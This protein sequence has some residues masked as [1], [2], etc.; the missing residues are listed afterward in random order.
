MIPLTLISFGGWAIVA[1]RNKSLKNPYDPIG[2]RTCTHLACSAISQPTAPM[3]I[4]LIGP[5][6]SQY[7]KKQFK[8]YLAQGH[9]HVHI[10]YHWT[11][12]SVM[13]PVL[14]LMPY[15]HLKNI[16]W[17]VPRSAKWPNPS[18]ICDQNCM[19]LSFFPCVLYTTCN[20]WKERKI[21]DIW[22]P[23]RIWEFLI[24]S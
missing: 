15:L 6:N 11:L 12:S 3:C 1:I 20:E 17:F 9:Y 21:V 5:Q 24:Y 13:D 10:S 19:Y 4:P 14:T 2:N 16:P 8:V 7:S 18:R 22:F 23:F